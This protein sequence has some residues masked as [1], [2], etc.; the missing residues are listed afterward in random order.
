MTQ[1]ATQPVAGL[2]GPVTWPVTRPVTWPVT[3]PMTGP[4]PTH[5]ESLAVRLTCETGA[6]PRA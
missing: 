5:D 6:C 1:P 3:Q 2:L 4:V